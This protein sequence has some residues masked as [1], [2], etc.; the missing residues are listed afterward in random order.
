MKE[1]LIHRGIFRFAQEDDEFTE[2]DR[3]DSQA[4]RGTFRGRH[5]MSNILFSD[6]VHSSMLFMP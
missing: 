2:I 4:G 6:K 5:M 1:Q 3:K